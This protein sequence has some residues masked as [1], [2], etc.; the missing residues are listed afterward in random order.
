MAHA[1]RVRVNLQWGVCSCGVDSSKIGDDAQGD[2][3]AQTSPSGKEGRQGEPTVDVTRV[4]FAGQ[5][6]RQN[7]VLCSMYVDC[8]IT[9]G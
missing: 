6:I 7:L 1:A 5:L 3:Q 9:A 4:P 2:G 8:A